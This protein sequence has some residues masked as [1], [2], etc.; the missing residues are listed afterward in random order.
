MQFLHC[1][2]GIVRG[3]LLT[4]KERALGSLL[5]GSRA[6]LSCS[7]RLTRHKCVLII[8]AASLMLVLV[9]GCS[10]D[11]VADDSE[12]STLRMAILVDDGNAEQV[13]AFEDFRLALE[14]YIGIKVE[15]IPGVTHLVAIETMRAGGLHLMWGSPFVYLLAQ[16]TMDVERLAVTS[17]PNAINKALFITSQDDINSMEDLE[18]RS[19]AFVSAASASGFLYPMY[20]LINSHGLSRDDILTPGVLFGDVTFSGS[21]NASIVGVANGDFDGGAVGHIQFNN[22]VNAGL[23][24]PQHVRI[25]G[26]TP[27]I[28]FPGYIASPSLSQELR[29]KIQSFLISWDSDEYSIARFNGDSAVRYA[30]PDVNEIEYLRSM[31]QIL[32]IDLAEQG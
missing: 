9:S 10:S 31:T 29:H 12:I 7:K 14:D 28:P 26:Y 18:N 20:Y 19:F 23:I 15:M 16:Q 5:R 8:V 1:E 3:T 4:C 6:I 21:N 32:D 11:N 30:L 17:S 25:L 22:A 27:N 13:N 2:P 24:D